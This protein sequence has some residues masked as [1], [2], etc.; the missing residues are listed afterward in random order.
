[1]SEKPGPGRVPPEDFFALLGLSPHPWVDTAE[2]K[3]NYHAAAS[4]AHPDHATGDAA[5][6]LRLGEAVACLKD[7]AARLRHL[8]ALQYGADLPK[9][10]TKPPMEIFTLVAESLRQADSAALQMKIANTPLGQAAAL[11][12]VQ[13]SVAELKKVLGRVEE[14]LGQ[15][16]A[17]CREAG[18][19][20]PERGADYWS[21]LAAEAVYLGKWQRQLGDQIFRLANLLPG[22]R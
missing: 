10:R 4:Q 18:A 7:P 8:V 15:L 19:D 14:A 21:G 17:T 6:F 22:S 2:L 5:H 1:M 12:A 9:I 3:Q 11:A 16:E 13:K 20:W